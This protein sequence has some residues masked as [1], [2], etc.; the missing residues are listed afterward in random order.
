M[1]VTDRMPCWSH[2]TSAI[3]TACRAQRSALTT[4]VQPWLAHDASSKCWRSQPRTEMELPLPLVVICEQ[5]QVT[6]R[7]TT[8]SPRSISRHPP[9]RLPRHFAERR[10]EPLR[11]MVW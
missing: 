11:R 5:Q 7:A 10:Q 2:H 3:A 1:R 8:W 6:T 4:R 9:C